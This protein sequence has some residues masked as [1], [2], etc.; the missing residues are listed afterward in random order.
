MIK[1]TRHVVVT[2][3]RAGCDTREELELEENEVDEWRLIFERAAESWHALADRSDPGRLPDVLCHRCTDFFRA[4][5]NDP[6]LKI[7]PIVSD[8]TGSG[9]GPLPDGMTVGAG[10]ETVRV[11]GADQ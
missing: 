9:E 2:C 1:T 6:N 5:L 7:L 8:G 3:D 4:W 11:D 10:G